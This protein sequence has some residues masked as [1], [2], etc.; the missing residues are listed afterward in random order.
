MGQC[1]VITEVCAVEPV[2][3]S[4]FGVLQG[5]SPPSTVAPAPQ[6][7]LGVEQLSDALNREISVNTSTEN[8]T[9]IPTPW[10]VTASSSGEPLFQLNNL[11]MLVLALPRKP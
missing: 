1:L 5:K 7:G 2:T 8:I 6:M 4:R 10:T 3:R 11:R 9:K